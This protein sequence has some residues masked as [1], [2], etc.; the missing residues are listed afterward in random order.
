MKYIIL[1]LS[2]M[3]GNPK[4]QEVE[5]TCP[6]P[7]CIKQNLDGN[8]GDMTPKPSSGNLPIFF[9]AEQEAQ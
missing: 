5:V 8:Q 4:A 3:W 6:G 7:H 2:H 9:S 1:S